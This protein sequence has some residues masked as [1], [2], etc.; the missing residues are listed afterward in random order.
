M[1]WAIQ[2]RPHRRRNLLLSTVITSN[3]LF[4]R[5]YASPTFGAAQNAISLHCFAPTTCCALHTRFVKMEMRSARASARGKLCFTSTTALRVIPQRTSVS[6]STLRRRVVPVATPTRRVRACAST[7]GTVPTSGGDGNGVVSTDASASASTNGIAS[8]GT[9]SE[10]EVDGGVHPSW[11]M[12]NSDDMCVVCQG[13]GKT[14]CAYCF[15]DGFVTIGPSAQ[16]DTITCPECDG[17]G[18]EECVRCDG[19]GKRPTTRYDIHRDEFVPNLTNAEVRK[20]KSPE[21]IER[22]MTAQPE[23]L[24]QEAITA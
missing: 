5:C 23:E 16:R 18:Y 15:G 21:E 12:Y 10:V 4:C 7:N 19:T 14:L 9:T 2:P 20:P 22:I 6:F 3:P 17:T 8:N 13:K 1:A 11:H 24:P